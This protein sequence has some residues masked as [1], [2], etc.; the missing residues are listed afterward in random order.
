VLDGRS[1][2]WALDPL[3]ATP[4]GGVTIQVGDEA[5]AE[6][7][8]AQLQVL[9]TLRRP[10][11]VVTCTDNPGHLAAACSD[12]PFE[13]IAARRLGEEPTA[14]VIRLWL[15]ALTPLLAEQGQWRLLFSH[16]RLGPI[17]ALDRAGALG[18]Q[19]SELQRLAMSAEAK[20]EEGQEK[21]LERWRAAFEAEGFT[22]A[23]ESWNETLQLELRDALLERW[24]APNGA[25]RRQLRTLGDDAFRAL[26]EDM[27]RC[28]GMKLPQDLRHTLLS[29]RR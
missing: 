19:L 1:L 11:L 17:T 26:G 2:L 25:Y 16:P 23:L 7:L 6:R 20:V 24:L 18:R 14:A 10:E 28:R 22:P 4:E 21:G 8:R 13:W 15:Q 29:A 3:Q 27:R 5:V 9:D 12:G